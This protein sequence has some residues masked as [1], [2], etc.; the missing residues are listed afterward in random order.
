MYYTRWH[1]NQVL[2]QI[3]QVILYSSFIFLIPFIFAIIFKE[4]TNYIFS[5]LISFGVAFLVGLILYGLIPKN[6][7][8]TL[9]SIHYLIIVAS[10]WLIFAALTTLPYYVFGYNFIDSFFDTTSILTTTGTTTLPFIVKVN[11]WHLWRA[12]LSWIGGIGIILIAYYGIFSSD[13]FTSKRIVRAG[14]YD[15]LSGGYK[16]SV[17]AIWIIY[18]IL[19]L[20][21]IILMLLVGVDLFN[22]VTYTMSAI[23]TT[24]H[25]MPNNDYLYQSSVQLIMSLIIFLGSISFVTHYRIYK[26]KNPFVYFKDPQF[27][28]M[29]LMIIVIF[30]IFFKHLGKIHSWQSITLLV[31]GT[32]GG[33]FTG[34]SPELIMGLAPILFFLLIFLMFVGGSKGSTSG[35]I[36]QGR[37]LLL[38][39]SV[40]WQIREIRLPDLSNVSR[41]YDGKVVENADIRALYFFIV[42]YVIFMVFGVLILTAYGYPLSAS[43]FEV[44]S[45][46]GN[47]GIETG[48]V[49]HGMPLFAKM[50]LIFNMW[51]GRLE[52]ITIFGLIG[53]IFQRVGGR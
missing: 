23:S 39:K 40:I 16:G 53:M 51:V 43:I 1:I 19:T 12:I 42:S 10:V 2:K 5:Y 3:G 36:T 14:G 8:V 33:G 49:N 30:F 45:T 26:E 38:M 44:V 52:I 17:R 32:L 47:I 46:Q 4:P 18:I 24:G 34:F 25:D 6:K 29:C 28:S 21:G 9:G 41:K 31:V 13:A 22:S 7:N 20:I 37:F 11:S 35:G 48:L 27:I 15:Q 50:V